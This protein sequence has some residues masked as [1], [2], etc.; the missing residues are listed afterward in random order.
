[1]V[2]SELSFRNGLG[3]SKRPEMLDVREVTPE[4]RPD[5]P[6]RRSTRST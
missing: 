6:A 2:M 1:M 4:L 5:V 3:G